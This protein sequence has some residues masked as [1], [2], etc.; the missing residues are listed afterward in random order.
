VG[1][2]KQEKEVETAVGSVARKGGA[3][4]EEEK[5]CEERVEDWCWEGGLKLWVA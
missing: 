1:E 3:P 4:R 2:K 5:K